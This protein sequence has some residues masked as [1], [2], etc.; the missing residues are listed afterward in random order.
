MQNAKACE[1]A[2]ILDH[3]TFTPQAPAYTTMLKNC[4]RDVNKAVQL[5]AAMAKRSDVKPNSITYRCTHKYCYS[6]SSDSKMHGSKNFIGSYWNRK[7][8]LWKE[9]S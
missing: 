1:V 2:R 6:P 4:G 9:V 3:L 7:H 8:M 5:W